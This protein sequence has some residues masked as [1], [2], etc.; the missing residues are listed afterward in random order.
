MQ[1]GYS[2]NPSGNPANPS[3]NPSANPPAN[4]PNI[5]LIR[6][7]D[8]VSFAWAITQVYSKKEEDRD[9]ARL[10]EE[11]YNSRLA[12][13]RQNMT[14]M[15]NVYIGAPVSSMAVALRNLCTYLKHRDDNFVEVE[16]LRDDQTKA[17]MH[18]DQ[19]A[20]N[21][22]TAFPK[23]A[24]STAIGGVAGFTLTDILTPLGIAPQYLPLAIAIFLGL[25][26]LFTEA[27]IV[28]IAGLA[29]ETAN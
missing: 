6:P 10:V 1:K 3:A 8:A 17:V 22:E 4:P 28:P 29:N 5:P 19:F 9:Q 21:F 23:I 11:Q 24:S 18:L 16:K 12:E 20:L 2:G 7:E 26:Y 27:L 14:S 13:F 15:D 25:G